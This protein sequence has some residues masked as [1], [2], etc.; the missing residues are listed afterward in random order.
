MTRVALT[1]DDG[2]SE[3]TIPIL[4]LLKAHDQHATFFVLGCHLQAHAAELERMVAEGHEIGL[5][6]WDHREVEGL[7]ANEL[8]GQIM[9]TMNAI[10]H[11]T[12]TSPRRWRSPWGK[13]DKRSAEVILNAGLRI[14]GLGIDSYDCERTAKDIQQA[15][16]SQL[17]DEAI[18]TLH[19]G[20]APNGHEQTKSRANTVAALPAILEACKSVTVSELLA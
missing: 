20:V 19:D 14:T 5:H 8:T 13:T 18:I 3:W 16:L 10:R 12:G 17:V 6:G 1:L 15:V 7:T 2:P 11:V 9:L 4:D